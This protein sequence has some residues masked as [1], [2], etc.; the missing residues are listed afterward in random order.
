MQEE[1]FSDSL[2]WHRSLL[3][4][5]SLSLLRMNKLFYIYCHDVLEILTKATFI[6]IVI[7]LKVLKW[8]QEDI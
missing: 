8:F 7:I 5:D 6:I 3:A 2:H 4:E 1:S